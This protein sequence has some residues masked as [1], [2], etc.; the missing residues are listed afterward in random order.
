MKT[1]VQVLEPISRGR[2]GRKLSGSSQ[3]RG[4][5]KAFRKFAHRKT[6]AHARDGKAF[7]QSSTLIL[8]LVK[9]AGLCNC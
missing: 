6:P 1:A 7:A 9:M 5:V 4:C 3:I 2:T 8:V